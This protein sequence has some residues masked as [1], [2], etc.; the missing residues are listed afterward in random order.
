MTFPHIHIIGA[1]KLGRTLSVQLTNREVPHTLHYRTFNKD[2]CGL[3]YCCVPE[4]AIADV[5]SQLTLNP[6][7]ILL[8]ASGSMGLEVLHPHTRRIGCLHPIQSFPGP[9]IS[10]PKTIPATFQCNPAEH[11]YLWPT[12]QWFAGLLGFELYHYTGSRLNYHTAAVI[13]GNFA[14]ILLHQAANLLVKEGLSIRDACQLLQPLATTSIA[15]AHKGTLADV[16]TGPISRQQ[17]ALLETQANNLSFDPDLQALYNLMVKIAAKS[18][19]HTTD[20]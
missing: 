11:E 19:E 2:L 5:A 17:D 4:D 7:S 3:I 16:L 6:D 18:Q 13:S 9:E 8:H 1:G 12:I 14:T 10:I 15:N 20:S